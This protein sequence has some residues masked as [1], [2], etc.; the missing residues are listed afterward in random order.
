LKR[1]SIDARPN[2]QSK[3]EELGFNWHTIDL[4]DG[5]DPTYWDESHAYAFSEAEVESV[6]EASEMLYRLCL[7]AVDYAIS[8]KKLSQLA[9]PPQFHDLVKRSWDRQDIDLYGRF[10]FGFDPN[11]VPKMLEFNA[12]TPTSLF[13]ASVVQW[14][15]LE[16][17]AKHTGQTLDQFNSIHE[18]LEETMRDIGDKLLGPN[19]SMYFSAAAENT[20]DQGTVNYLRDLAI[21]AG[22]RT[23]YIDIEMIGWNGRHFVDLEE[24]PIN[25][26]FKLY[27][28]EWLIREEGS[29]GMMQE[30][31]DII[32][33]AWKLVLSNKGILPILWELYPDCPYLL[34]TYWSASKAGS[35]FVEKPLL[36][37]EGADIKIYKEGQLASTGT[38]RNYDQLA[39]SIYQEYLPLPKFDGMTPIIGSWIIG[40]RPAG[41]GIRESE[42]EIT[43]NLAHFVPHYFK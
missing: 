30:K 24:R 21:Q 39:P 8:E 4:G 40:G 9:I 5:T 2:W 38:V 25:T 23:E 35:N 33:P 22:L 29:V 17:Y 6:E 41:M 26:L 28:W 20:E 36:A 1:I 31:W 32:E 14:T 27:P 11:G 18:K 37:R 7:S 42:D 16:D 43:G 13:E 12:D 3:V 15:W 34:P 19:E 10:D